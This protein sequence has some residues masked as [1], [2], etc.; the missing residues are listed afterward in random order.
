MQ[1]KKL[2]FKI[3]LLLRIHEHCPGTAFALVLPALPLAWCL[4]NPCG[5]QDGAG[6]WSGDGAVGAKGN[7]WSLWAAPKQQHQGKEG[8]QGTRQQPQA[9]VASNRWHRQ[10]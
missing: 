1:S 8:A 2:S 6:T 3:F 10:K 9:E 4:Q 7:F 5:A